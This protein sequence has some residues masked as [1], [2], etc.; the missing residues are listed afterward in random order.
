MVLSMTRES[1]IKPL[2]RM[3]HNS[4]LLPIGSVRNLAYN[5]APK[6]AS[7]SQIPA[8]SRSDVPPPGKNW[9]R[10]FSNAAQSLNLCE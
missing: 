4:Y 5:I 3:S 10:A 9:S 2:L 7:V 8:T 6:R 1:T